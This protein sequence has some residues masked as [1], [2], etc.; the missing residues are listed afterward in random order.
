[1]RLDADLRDFESS[2]TEAIR[3]RPLGSPEPSGPPQ[4]LRA[5]M[6]RNHLALFTQEVR[7]FLHRA[8]Y[9]TGACLALSFVLS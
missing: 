5:K 3:F 7:L 1:M 2:L 8:H 4:S 9:A 6:Q